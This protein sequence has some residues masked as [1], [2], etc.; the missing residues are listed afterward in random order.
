VKDVYAILR[1]IRAQRFSRN[2]NFDA[3]RSAESAEARRLP[4]R[5]S[6]PAAG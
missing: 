6:T 1:S 5:H 2:R 4:K 3:H